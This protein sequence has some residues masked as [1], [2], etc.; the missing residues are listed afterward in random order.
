[1]VVQFKKLDPLA[2]TPSYAKEGDAGLDIT[3]TKV[4]SIQGENESGEVFYQIKIY[5]GLAFEIPKGYVG[6]LFPRSSVKNFKARLTNSVGVIDSGYRGEVT[7][8]FDV[9]QP[10]SEF[11]KN[12]TAVLQMIILPF[13]K[14]TLEEIK[15]LSDSERGD[16]GYGHTGI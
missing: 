12:G 11:Y 1:M 13:P 5:T 10:I 6:L 9:P 14:I 3:P 8:Y 4:E 15:E 2:I 16:K 7:G